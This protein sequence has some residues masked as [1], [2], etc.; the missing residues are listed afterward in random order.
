VCLCVLKVM[1]MCVPQSITA[2][3]ADP[4]HKLPFVFV[5]AR[6]CVCVCVYVCVCVCVCVCVYVG[7]S[8]SLSL[9]IFVHSREAVDSSRVPSKCAHRFLS[10]FEIVYR[11]LSIKNLNG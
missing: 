2:P 1:C 6:V 3:S 7:V 9:P 11:L 4:E 8:V 10:K 5:Y